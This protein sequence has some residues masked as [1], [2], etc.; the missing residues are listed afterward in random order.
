MLSG[1]A[2]VT[3]SATEAARAERIACELDGSIEEFFSDVRCELSD[4]EWKLLS[5][6]ARACVRRA[7]V[8]GA[9]LHG[10]V[11]SQS[12]RTFPYR[13]RG[14]ESFVKEGIAAWRGAFAP[15]P[16]VWKLVS[17]FDSAAGG[18]QRILADVA[19]LEV[20]AANRMF[21]SLDDQCAEFLASEGA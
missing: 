7:M 11:D 12:D 21:A 4:G 2:K 15:I 19:T 18:E 13:G 3:L 20:M 1:M 9:L 8:I 16:E 5:D 14:R 6:Y 17:V 10:V